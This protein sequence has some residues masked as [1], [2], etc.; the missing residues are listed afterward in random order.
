M[1][2]FLTGFFEVAGLSVFYTRRKADL[3]FVLN[4]TSS[5]STFILEYKGYLVIKGSCTCWLVLNYVELMWFFVCF[6]L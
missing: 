4:N 6:C 5:D 2:D 3:L 1:P